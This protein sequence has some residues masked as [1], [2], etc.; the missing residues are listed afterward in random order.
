LPARKISTVEELLEAFPDVRDLLIDGTERSIQRP[1]DDEKQKEL[2][3][4]AKAWNR[5]V[6]GFRVLLEHA[7]GG[8][9]RFG[10]V[11]DKFR[12]RKDG[13][14]DKVMVLCFAQKVYTSNKTH[15]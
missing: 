2:T 10:I 12:N 4:D 8:V 14:G 15:F 1:K 13:F 6:S 7:I 5:I 3:D 9:K 11:S